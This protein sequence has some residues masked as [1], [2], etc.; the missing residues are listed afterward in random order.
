[1]DRPSPNPSPDPLAVLSA[2]L[3]GARTPACVGI[4]PVPE[5]IPPEVGGASEMDT[6]ER[7][8]LGALDAVSGVVGV[9][10][11]QSACFERFGSGGYRVL[12]RVVAQAR[13]LGFVVILDA[14]RADIGSSAAHYAAGAEAMGAHWIT[15]SPYMGRSSIEP[16][17]YHG[18]GVFALC[19]T[20]NPDAREI[21]SGASGAVA[22]MIA[23][24][25]VGAV[26]GATL[27]P[28][29]SA[30]LRRAMPETVFL[31]PGVGAQGGTADAAGAMA[32]ADR[33][34]PSSLGL[35]INA[36]RSVLYPEGGADAWDE[37]IARAAR[38]HA[39]VCAG[40]VTP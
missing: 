12:E 16:F 27:D 35:V 24:M 10:K 29:E 30:S 6:L 13:E 32:R 18:L 1:M 36:S 20:S 26:I 5:R 11:P 21:Q 2:A 17:L 39:C 23:S 37:R 14:K 28:E 7:F 15:I 40:L 38:E 19:R 34:S 22:S 8:C 4:D 31:V 3:D 25:G 9:V 33:S